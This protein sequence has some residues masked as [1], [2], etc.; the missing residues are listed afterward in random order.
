MKFLCIVNKADGYAIV[1]SNLNRKQQEINAR[2]PTRGAQDLAYT[3][4]SYKVDANG[5]PI[6]ELWPH[7]TSARAYTSFYRQ[8]GVD[9]SPSVDVPNTFNSNIVTESA[10]QYAYDWAIANAGRFTELKDVEWSLLKAEG[11]RRLDKMILAAQ[12]KDNEIFE[13]DYIVQLRDYLTFPPID[14]KFFQSHD[15]GGWFDG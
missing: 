15:A 5:N 7:P 1:G 14:S 3:V 9:L 6:Y 2:D 12:V 13:Q 8:R 4:S 11:K 10:K